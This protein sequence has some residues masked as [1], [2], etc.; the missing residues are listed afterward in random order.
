M[1]ELRGHRKG[2]VKLTFPAPQYLDFTPLIV[3]AQAKS[4]IT[5]YEA[6]LHDDTTNLGDNPEKAA[7]EWSKRVLAL[8][9]AYLSYDISDNP[10]IQATLEQ[11]RLPRGTDESASWFLNLEDIR[12]V[13][14]TLCYMF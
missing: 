1:I 3:W 9:R 10:T 6:I 5:T 4:H 11:F 13:V 12:N 7:A 2:R 14:G 8:E